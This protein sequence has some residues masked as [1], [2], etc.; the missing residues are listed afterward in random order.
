ML[1]AA[2]R[3]LRFRSPLVFFALVPTTAVALLVGAPPTPLATGWFVE[4]LT[5]LGGPAE[6]RD[7]EA[8]RLLNEG[9]ALQREGRYAAAIERYRA[10]L[11][12]PESEPASRTARFLLGEALYLDDRDAEAI[13]ALDTFVERYP[14]DPRRLA[15]TGIRAKA[16]QILGNHQE[17]IRLFRE[18]RESPTALDGYLALEIGKSL[19]ALGRHAEAI[20]ELN[21]AASAGLARLA[22]IDAL[23]KLADSYAKLGDHASVALTWQRVAPLAQTDAYKA[24][25]RYRHAGALV[26]IGRTSDAAALYLEVMQAFPHTG[27]AAAALRE[28]ARLGVDPG[29]Y[30]R[31]LILYH[32]D[33]ESEAVAALT[34]FLAR[35]PASPNAADALLHRG[36][37]YRYLGAPD[38]AAA[39]FDR[40]ATA[41]PGQRSAD[42]AL[43]QAGLMYEAIGRSQAAV[44][45]YRRLIEGIPGSSRR[46]EARLRL[47]LVHIELNDLAAAEALLT[48]AARAARPEIAAAAQLWL[49]KLA[50]ARGDRAA[51][52]S[53]WRAAEQAAPVDLPGLRAR[54]LR[55]GESVP[56]AAAPPGAAFATDTPNDLLE[57]DRWVSALA[58]ITVTVEMRRPGP[59]LLAEPAFQRGEELLRAGFYREATEEFRDLAADLRRDPLALYQL[60]LWLE[61]RDLARATAFAGEQLVALS[62]AKSLAGV[63][64]KLLRLVLPTPYRSLV[65]ESARRHGVDP[66]LLLALIRQE[67]VYDRYARSVAG[68]RGL[69]QVMPA[70]G[71][72]IARAL[73]RADF[74]VADLYRPETS[75]EFGAYYFGEQLRRFAGNA[76][77][78]MGAYNAGPG[79][80]P[81]W[82]N[83][84]LAFDP[85]LFVERIPYRETSSYVRLVGRYYYLYRL[86]YRD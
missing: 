7:L 77:F 50:A 80:I 68:A 35:E 32:A 66:A 45:F 11:E 16:H 10:V 51:A 14:D 84:N 73:G 4:Q 26:R 27:W 43:F 64:R 6:T 72:G 8:E 31:G 29:P 71:E 5:A 48:D 57:L 40:A 69:T 60:A 20:V 19:A 74:T 24:E 46:D 53:A 25:V 70:T 76:Y 9:I 79:V 23:E 30:L 65:E 61:E 86:A 54:A 42:E 67:S 13:A 2:L 47:A 56:S 82:T 62:P 21:L 55:L 34:D 18:Y 38:R 39:D 59:A 36:L 44:P 28:G 75:I 85:D 78:A 17:A 12:R 41:Y 81:R 52:E 58:G 22:T 15:A 83:G 33:R 37:A 3:R 49:G 1:R 63:P